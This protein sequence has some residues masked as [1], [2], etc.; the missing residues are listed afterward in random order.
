MNEVFRE[1]L[2]RFEI[3]YIDDILI[4]SRNLAEN[5]PHVMQFLEYQLYLKLEK[6]EFH[7]PTVQFL[8]YNIS[9]DGIYM[10]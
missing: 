2:H 9:A 4:Y 8:G 3:V 6:W 5:C 7:H 10:D 1:F